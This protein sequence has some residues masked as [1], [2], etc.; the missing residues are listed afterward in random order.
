MVKIGNESRQGFTAP[1]HPCF[2]PER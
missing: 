2:I 1:H